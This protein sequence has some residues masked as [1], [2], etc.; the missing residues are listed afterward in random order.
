MEYQENG[1]QYEKFSDVTGNAAWSG[2]GS[3]GR[4]TI[5]KLDVTF[6]NQET[7]DLFLTKKHSDSLSKLILK[8]SRRQG[9]RKGLYLP[10][11][12]RLKKGGEEKEEEELGGGGGGGDEEEE[13]KE[14]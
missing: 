10:T 12:S 9:N 3:L 5:T 1:F 6:S 13:S 8:T 4:R 2:F 11:N 7:E 14:Q